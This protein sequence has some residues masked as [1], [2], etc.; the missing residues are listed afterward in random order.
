MFQC[1]RQARQ[2]RTFILILVCS[3]GVLALSQQLENDQFKI[4]FSPAGLTSLKR[5]QDAFDT[6]YV[7][8]GRSLGDILVRYRAP[9][10]AWKDISSGTSVSQ[11][12]PGEVT[13]QIGR[14]VPT[15]ATASRTNSSIGPWRTRA[16][17]DQAEPKNSRDKNIPFF[18]WGD[19]HGSEEWVEYDFPEPKEV[20]SAEV[21]WAIGSYEDYR[22]DLPVSWRT[23][24]R[25]GD[26]WKDVLA[27][28][29]YGIAPDRFNHVS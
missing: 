6:D 28:A 11:H 2:L 1:G 9:G 18:T 20:S 4:A 13:Y 7:L 17:N 8:G 5:A 24:Y 12:S 15:I 29:G 10:E 22:W 23:Q 27:S 3:R 21:Y 14:A 25:D 19:K 26:Q 16:L